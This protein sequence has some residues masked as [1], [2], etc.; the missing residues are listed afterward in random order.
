MT[1]YGV[2][3]C[4]I[5]AAL[6]ALTIFVIRL[7][8]RVEDTL[9]TANTLLATTEQSL[10]ETTA[11]VNQNLYNMK[12]ITE[13]INSFT[14]DVASFGSSIKGIGDEVK[15]LMEN[16]KGVSEVVHDLGQETSASMSGLRAGILTGIDVFFKNLFQKHYNR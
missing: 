10:K 7:I 9:K 4:F 13:N 12:Q 14:G 6:V 5:T 8:W 3:L 2:L 16:I 11:E 1:L 15:Q